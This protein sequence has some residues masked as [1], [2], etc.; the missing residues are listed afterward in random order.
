MFWTSRASACILVIMLASKDPRKSSRHRNTLLV[1]EHDD[2]RCGPRTTLSTRPFA[3]ELGG[4]VVFEGSFEA[5]LND[6]TSLTAKY[7]RG[8]AE[9]KIPQKRRKPGKEK[10]K[11]VGAREH[12]LQNVSVEIPLEMLVCVTGVSGSGK[13]TLST[14]F[15]TPFGK[16]ARRMELARRLSK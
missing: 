9:I 16:N 8:D 6:E 14:M 3:G 12:N 10:I 5:L 2:T 1:V 7:L 13:S 11:I 15:C 4:E